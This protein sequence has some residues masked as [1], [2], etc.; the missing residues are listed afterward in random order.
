[1]SSRLI[2][3]GVF[4]I[5]I[6]TIS[7]LYKFDLFMFNSIDY[8]YFISLTLILLG[9]NILLKKNYAKILI[10][11]LISLTLSFGIMKFVGEIINGCE[12]TKIVK[13]HIGNYY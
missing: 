4:L 10:T 8:I 2:F 3:W 7:L 6:G 1:M 9:L 13:V 11:I 5:S 12:H